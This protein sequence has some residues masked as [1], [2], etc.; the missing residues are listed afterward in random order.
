[1]DLIGYDQMKRL[2]IKHLNYWT[3]LVDDGVRKNGRAGSVAGV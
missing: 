3:G 1:M 2:G